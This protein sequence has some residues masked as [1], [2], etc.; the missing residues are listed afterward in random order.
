MGACGVAASMV[1]AVFA[2]SSSSPSYIVCDLELGLAISVLFGGY[3][4]GDGKGHENVL[5]N[6]HGI[7]SSH[8]RKATGNKVAIL[9]SKSQYRIPP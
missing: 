1:G 2:S 3:A 5:S 6:A 4:A 7:I 8:H 9:T